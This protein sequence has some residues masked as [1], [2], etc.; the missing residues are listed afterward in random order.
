MRPPISRI[1][2]KLAHPS[3]SLLFQR[4][5]SSSPKLKPHLQQFRWNSS[6]KSE[7]TPP[8]KP[9]KPQA[10]GKK[11]Q[12]EG[13]EGPSVVQQP[14]N[15]PTGVSDGSAL[16]AGASP[17]LGATF[18]TVIGLAVVFVGGI[19]YF[20]WYKANVIRKMEMA[21]EPGYDPALNLADHGIKTR[22]SEA[23]S[24]VGVD[25]ASDVRRQ[26][27]DVIDEIVHGMRHG[28]Y[29][30]MMGSKGVGK[31]TMIL[32][33]MRRVKADG[34][35]ICEA[36]E[37][38]EVFRLRL[39][40]ALNYEYN[41]DSQTG[42]FQRRDPREGTIP[43]C[44]MRVP[45]SL[46]KLEKVAL[47]MAAKRQKPLV[48][49]INNCQLFNNDEDSHQL[50]LQLQQKAESWA[51]SHLITVVFST[52][53]FWPYPLMRKIANRMHVISVKDLR[54]QESLSALRHLRQQHFGQ[55]EDDSVLLEVLR[56]SGGRLSRLN[57]LSREKDIVE[58]TEHM[59]NNEKGWILSVIGLIPDCDD[60]VMDEQKVC[61]SSWTLLR[62]FVKK[63]R[64]KEEEL[65]AAAKPG[66][67]I[68]EPELPGISYYEARQI[69]T[70]AD[71][72]EMLDHQN[73][74]NI[75]TDHMVRP[76]SMVVLRAAIEIVEEPGF[77]ELLDGVKNRIDAIESLHRTREL[78]VRFLL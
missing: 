40:K 51:E 11:P 73:I 42:L 1:H 74:I 35:A 9:V 32:D 18:T 56:T 34:V 4:P 15:L 3:R 5:P 64:E 78:T 53:D 30:L 68:P 57:T 33:A 50:L 17:L 26:E 31:T 43:I 24:T 14:L 67:F 46:N 16:L 23:T 41:E 52:D 45:P 54:G 10:D 25:W 29:I 75:D 48:L 65:R 71:F 27:Q 58:A 63:Y 62:E 22:S 70:R 8:S 39:G 2:I 55:S 77:D 49:V 28:H 47:K 59:L 20:E 12:Q 72:L 37:D 66:E 44:Y 36:H 69:M 19:F 61:S 38:L 13:Y 21:F 6:S 7:S 76:D 60:D